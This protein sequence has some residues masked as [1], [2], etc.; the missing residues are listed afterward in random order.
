MDKIVQTGWIF[1]EPIGG[2]LNEANE[3]PSKPTKSEVISPPAMLKFLPFI[4]VVA[5]FAL[6]N[7]WPQ[8][9]P[10]P[11]RLTRVPAVLVFVALSIVCVYRRPPMLTTPVPAEL[12]KN[13][14]FEVYE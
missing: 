10:E 13:N 9:A 2:M 12:P 14:V 5:V 8:K 6:P 11:S 4:N 1:F 3:D 7:N